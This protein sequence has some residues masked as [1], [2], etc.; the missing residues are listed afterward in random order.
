MHHLDEYNRILIHLQQD[1]F[2]KEWFISNHDTFLAM[3]CYDY[4][5]LISHLDQYLDVFKDNN[6][7]SLDKFTRL[8]A[9]QI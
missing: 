7:L 3:S 5:T 9:T 1:T 4:V 2:K 6:M 8:L